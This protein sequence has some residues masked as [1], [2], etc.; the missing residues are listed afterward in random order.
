MSKASNTE[1][2]VIPAQASDATALMKIIDRAA[3][4]PSFDVAKLQQLLDMK[5][6]WD[7]MEAKKSFVSALNAFKA[8]PPDVFKT[9]RVSFKETSYKHALLSDAVEVI[10]AALSKHGLS[11]R[12]ECEQ[13]DGGMIRVT[14]ILTHAQG[15]S[16]RVS[17]QAGADQTG[18]KNNIQALGSTVSYLER[19]TLFAITGLAAKDM[20]DDGQTAEIEFITDNQAADLSALLEEVGADKVKFCE[21]FKISKVEELPTK[22]HKQAV[23]LVEAKRKKPQA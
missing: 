2:Q 10:G 20:D 1:M 18:A 19:Y 15:H 13:L 17:L 7:A 21:Y 12:W 14:C 11:F 6:R 4:D 22:A 16:E 23:A 5:E 9:K 3:T 8:D